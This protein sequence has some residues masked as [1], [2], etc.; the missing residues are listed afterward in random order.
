MIPLGDTG[1]PPERSFPIVN[2][3]I[4]V[5]NLLMFLAQMA[6]GDPMNNGWTLIPKEITTGQD[7]VGNFNIPDVGAIT[8][9]PA[10]LGIPWLTLFTSMFMHAGW[11]HIGGNMLFLFIFGDNVE[12]NLGHLKYLVFYLLCGLAADA[13]QIFFGGADSLIPN[14][15]ASGAIA[16]VLAGYIVLFPKARIRALIPFGYVGMI[17]YVPAFIMIG[18][19]ILTQVISIFPLSEQVGG[20]VAF[21]AHI[22]GFILGLVLILLLGDRQAARQA[23]S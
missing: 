18:I 8:L 20:G 12:D 16:G 23:Y 4:I 1:T 13:T 6:I 17:G 11:L 21:F 14:L 3:A 19:W 9:Y 10:P 5:V 22:G 15:G 7:L 2:I